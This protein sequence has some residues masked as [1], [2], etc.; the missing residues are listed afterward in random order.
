MKRLNQENINTPALYEAIYS[1]PRRIQLMAVMPMRTLLRAMVRGGEALDV[2][3]GVGQY[4]PFLAGADAVDGIDFSPQPIAEA[5]A[6]GYRAVY[7]QDFAGGIALPD[8]S[9]DWLFC[10]EVLEHMDDPAALVADMHRLLRPG[11]VLIATTPY[12][13]AI[14]CEEHVWAFDEDDLRALFVPFGDWATFR[15]S[16]GMDYEHFLVVAVK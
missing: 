14:P 16:V 3:C 15:Y 13:D 9:Y 1:G 2:G 12:R 7:E 6:L 8:A 10:A 4:Y 11:G 5:R